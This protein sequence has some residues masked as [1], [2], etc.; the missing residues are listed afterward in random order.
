M[1]LSTLKGKVTKTFISV[2]GEDGEPPES[3]E[4]HYRPG[5]LTLEVSDQLRAASESDW[6][7]DII[8][9]LLEPLLVY[10]D[11]EEDILDEEGEPTGEVRA[12][13]TSSKDI[14]K[15][16][17]T[18]LGLVMDQVNLESRPGPLTVE[19]SADSSLPEVSTDESQ[20]GTQ[21]S[22]QPVT[23]ES[24]PGSFSADQ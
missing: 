11:L 19:I 3:V 13:T 1:K 16:P 7:I 2:P 24:P 23:L 22:E 18:F 9:T 14:R 6:Q 17:L 5:A 21:S 10:W 8:S 20:N 4:V 12:L 15:V